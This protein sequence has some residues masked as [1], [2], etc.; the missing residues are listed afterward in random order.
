MPNTPQADNSN[1]GTGIHGLKP[2][3]N[4]VIT[5]DIAKTWKEWLQQ[6]KSYA[7]AIQLEK[8]NPEMQAATFMTIIGP[9]A[10]T[11]FNT[12]AL[13]QEEQ[14]NIDTII[15]KFETYFTPKV[16]LTYERYTFNKM[17]QEETGN[18]SEFL[19]KIKTV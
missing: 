15:N 7:T 8:F 3:K 4:L 18:F 2:P 16:N 19:T 1:V 5:E 11:I 6:Y 10:I 9:D 13:S 14:K 12:F 17:K